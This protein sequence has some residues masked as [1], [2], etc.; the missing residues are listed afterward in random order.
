MKNMSKLRA[1]ILG[2][3]C[4]LESDFIKIFSEFFD[5]WSIGHYIDFE[6]PVRPTRGYDITLPRDEEFI[7]LC[8]KEIP[9]YFPTQPLCYPK[10]IIDY[11]KPDIIVNQHY[12]E[13]LIWNEKLFSKIPLKIHYSICMTS[14]HLE[15]GIK[16]F[17]IEKEWKVVRLSP[18]ERLTP[19]YA[20]EDAVIR[21]PIDVKQFSPWIGDELRVVCVNKW[22]AQRGYY[23]EMG[24][25]DRVTKP[26]NRLLIGEGNESIPG[27]LSD[28]PWNYILQ[29]L[30]RSRCAYSGVSKPSPVTYTFIEKLTAGCPIVT[31]G[32]IKGNDHA[33]PYHPQ[34]YEAHTFIKNGVNGFWSDDEDELKDYIRMLFNDYNLAK[35]ISE[36][37]RK[38]AVEHFSYDVIKSQWENLFKKWGLIN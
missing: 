33:N 14:S 5:V 38:T 22:M 25:W 2:C 11:V 13:N 15:A 21:Q 9:S 26:F 19:G 10:S 4:T 37:G 18:M 31:I 36:E 24:T 16:R 34:A 1:L 32:P 23:A 28:A 3:H 30:S 8:K 17:G 27:A 35:S 20:G 29:C 6:N 12:V 7:S